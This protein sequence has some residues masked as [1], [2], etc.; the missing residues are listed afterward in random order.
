MKGEALRFAVAK[1]LGIRAVEHAGGLWSLIWADGRWCPHHQGGISEEHA[2]RVCCPRFDSDLNAAIELTNL[3]AKE[4]W[5]SHFNNGF[6]TT[7][8]VVISTRNDPQ[9]RACLIP[10]E[11]D[12]YGAANTLAGAICEAFLQK[13][14]KWK[15]SP[16]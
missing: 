16:C 5:R 14:G 1:E 10:T 13:L 4:G 15:D 2:W 8:E 11:D 7:W 12:F 6:D 3:L 9:E